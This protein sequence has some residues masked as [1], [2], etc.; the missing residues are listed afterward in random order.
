MFTYKD[1]DYK[2]S[3]SNYKT[4]VA[5]LTPIEKNM[6]NINLVASPC[7]NFNCPQY[8]G[9]LILNVVI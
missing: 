7:G 3:H 9:K 2:R 6:E 8:C 5:L 4:N 1:S